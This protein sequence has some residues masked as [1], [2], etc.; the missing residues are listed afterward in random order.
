MP[1]YKLGDWL[2]KLLESIADFLI[3]ILSFQDAD[4]DPKSKKD[5]NNNTNLNSST[6]LQANSTSKLRTQQQQSNAVGLPR[7][8]EGESTRRLRRNPT[9]NPDTAKKRKSIDRYDVIDGRTGL[10]N[11]PNVRENDIS[12][13]PT[14]IALPPVP[15]Q[16]IDAEVGMGLRGSQP[17]ISLD[18]LRILSMPPIPVEESNMSANKN[19]SS[20]A[21]R[22]SI[23]LSTLETINSI[24]TPP[25]TTNSTLKSSHT[26][27]LPHIKYHEITLVECIGNGGFGQVWKGQWKGTP[28]AVKMIAHTGFL[29]PTTATATATTIPTAAINDTL[30]ALAPIP[31]HGNNGNGNTGISDK[32]IKGFEEEVNL[33]GQLR[34]PNICLL[35][36]I[37]MEGNVHFMIT[38]LVS[39]GS[40]WDQLRVP[41]L[42]KVTISLC[43]SL[44]LCLLYICTIVTCHGSFLLA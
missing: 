21:P 19:G 30:H 39:R 6:W 26:Y 44:S 3:L 15:F 9:N 43:L 14:G 13:Q 7:P 41:H 42:F 40:L 24:H 28:I 29:L 23:P 12:Q 4:L 36:G 25:T 34:H 18:R 38:E 37:C 35:L 8:H 10:F 33:L 31:G 27:V 2:W 1:L 32:L 11:K 20:I 17:L 5:S 22:S 16:S